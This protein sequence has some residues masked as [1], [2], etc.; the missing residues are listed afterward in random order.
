[1][2][3][4]AYIRRKKN[5]NDEQITN[6]QPHTLAAIL[7]GCSKVSFSPIFCHPHSQKL[8]TSDDFYLD[9]SLPVCPT[10]DIAHN[11]RLH[12]NSYAEL[13][14][15]LKPPTHKPDQTVYINIKDVYKEA[16]VITLPSREHNISTTKFHH[17]GSMHQIDEKHIHPIDLYI[18]STNDP[19]KNKFFPSWLK[20]GANITIRLDNTENYQHGKPLKQ[21]TQ[22]FLNPADLRKKHNSTQGFRDSS[23]ISYP[24]SIPR[25]SFFQ[26]SSRIAAVTIHR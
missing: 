26:E 3:S 2:F 17:D 22:Y 19:S 5:T 16:T 23:T 12:F 11:D 20:H 24:T 14:A 10:F 25:S 4:V 9:E 6:S 21:G 8:I 13:N 18:L 7:V 1:M 15:Y